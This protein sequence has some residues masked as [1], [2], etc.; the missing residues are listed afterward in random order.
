MKPDEQKSSLGVQPHARRRIGVLLDALYNEYAAILVTA[1]EHEAKLRDVDLYCFA[2]GALHSLAGHELSRNRCYDLVSE[3]ALDGIVVFS[4]SASSE[5]IETF[6]GRYPQLP[7]VTIGHLVPGI[8]VVVSDNAAGMREAVVHLISAHGRRKIVFLRGPA[9][10]Q[11]AQARFQAYRDALRDFGLE[12]DPALVLHGEFA[13]E[14]GKRAMRDFM[15]QRLDFDALVGAND[16][17]VLGAL[18]VLHEHD[19]SL[20]HI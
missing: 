8:P 4:L 12:Y 1:F 15:E 6:L 20:I 14:I 2:G 10:N 9:T 19:L 3:R 17:S 13:M 18:E 16:L 7:R 11:E 5:V